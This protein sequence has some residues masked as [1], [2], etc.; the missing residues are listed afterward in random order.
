MCPLATLSWVSNVAPRSLEL[1]AA[2]NLAGTLFRQPLPTNRPVRPPEISGADTPWHDLTRP[3]RFRIHPS[4]AA[5]TQSRARSTQVSFHSHLAPMPVVQ[6]RGSV[7]GYHLA[8][9]VGWEV[10]RTKTAIPEITTVPY[11]WVLAEHIRQHGARGECGEN[12]AC[13]KC[14]TTAWPNSP[15]QPQRFVRMRCSCFPRMVDGIEKKMYL[16]LP[17]AF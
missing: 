9:G 5:K 10:G 3:D 2:L 1:G 4:Q 14:N 17:M 6:V 13:E 15:C 7:L 16:H 11:E 8:M 12:A